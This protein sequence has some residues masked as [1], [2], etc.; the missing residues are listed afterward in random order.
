M[1]LKTATMFAIIGALIEL[2]V[3][4]LYVLIGFQII[5]WHTLISRITSI[6][7]LLGFI[8]LFIFFIVFYSKQK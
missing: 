3:Q 8:G 2:F 4:F 7:L 5:K 1:K 6:A